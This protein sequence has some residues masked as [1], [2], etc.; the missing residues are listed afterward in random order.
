MATDPPITLP[1]SPRRTI[2][3]P[4]PELPPPRRFAFIP[5][6]RWN[7]WVRW[8]NVVAGAWLFISPFLWQHTPTSDANSWIV[9]P[10]IV[11]VA[12]VALYV[13][14][15]R[16][17][18]TAL[19]VWL[20]FSTLVFAHAAPRTLWNNLIV[21][22]IVFVASLMPEGLGASSGPNGTGRIPMP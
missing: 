12:I 15:V 14:Q 5:P 3:L 13:P 19:A 10:L 9:G 16:W 8:V 11:I 21:A 20:F 17:I 18:N 6:P 4:P 1:P 7:A 22:L 2:E